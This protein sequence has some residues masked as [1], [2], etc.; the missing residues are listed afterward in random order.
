MC[1]AAKEILVLDVWVTEVET[2]WKLENLTEE[3]STKAV[4]AFVL[5]N[6][7]TTN[8]W[9]QEYLENYHYACLYAA[10]NETLG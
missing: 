9:K 2:G 7:C 1:T 4:T 6:P 5:W 10:V 8:C 3:E